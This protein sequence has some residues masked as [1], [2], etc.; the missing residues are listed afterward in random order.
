MSHDLFHYLSLKRYITVNQSGQNF[1][2]DNKTTAMALELILV[3]EHLTT[4]FSIST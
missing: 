4:P 2:R 3:T 1:I